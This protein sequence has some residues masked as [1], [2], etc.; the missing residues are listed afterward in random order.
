MY[1][2]SDFVEAT[3]DWPFTTPMENPIS[4][5]TSPISFHVLHK[6]IDNPHSNG[7]SKTLNPLDADP[8]Y[9]AKVCDITFN[10][11]SLNLIRIYFFVFF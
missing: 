10:F 1:I 8:R 3:V 5:C 9:S 11:L 6:D 2:P 4:I 7:E